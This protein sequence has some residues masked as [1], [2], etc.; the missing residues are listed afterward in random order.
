VEETGV[1]V[2]KNRKAD[3]FIKVGILNGKSK[4]GQLT[5]GISK[6]RDKNV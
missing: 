4:R 5:N 6:C 1:G 3:N 2:D